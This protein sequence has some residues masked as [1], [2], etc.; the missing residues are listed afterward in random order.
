MCCASVVW[1]SRYSAFTAL[2]LAEGEWKCGHCQPHAMWWPNPLTFVRNSQNI[3]L[4]QLT[5]GITA[6]DI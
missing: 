3:I 5:K 4:L 6:F 2:E 1:Y